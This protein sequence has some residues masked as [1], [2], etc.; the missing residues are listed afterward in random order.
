MAGA[1]G[2]VLAGEL[3]VA[4]EGDVAGT[5]GA[6]GAALPAAAPGLALLFGTDVSRPGEALADVAEA[7]GCDGEAGPIAAVASAF[8]FEPAPHPIATTRQRLDT[9]N[10]DLFDIESPRGVTQVNA[11][12]SYFTALVSFEPRV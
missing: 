11:S 8:G 5:V 3:G 12:L 1:A 9:M 10:A 6:A 4:A 2:V 7:A